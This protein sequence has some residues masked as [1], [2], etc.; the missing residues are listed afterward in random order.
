MG[1]AQAP[2]VMPAYAGVLPPVD[3]PGKQWWIEAEQAFYSLSKGHSSPL[4][5]TGDPTVSGPVTTSVKIPTSPGF[6]GLVTT[7]NS[8]GSALANSGTLF[9]GGDGLNTGIHSGEALRFG[10]W[11]DPEHTQAI[12]GGGFYIG[13]GSTGFSSAPGGNGVAVPFFDANGIGQLFVVNRPATSTDNERI[14]EHDARRIRWPVQQGFNGPVHGNRQRELFP[15]PLGS[16]PQLSCCH[17]FVP[18]TRRGSRRLRWCQVRKP[19]RILS[20]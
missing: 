14:G 15:K 7:Q 17:A 18:G 5:V 6:I 12:E 1:L 10:H 11:L 16:R 13:Q 19:Q 3:S 9:G 2:G 4:I 20:P 8:L